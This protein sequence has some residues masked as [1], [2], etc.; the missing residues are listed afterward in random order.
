MICV[1]SGSSVS[2]V[3]GTTG[4]KV[5]SGSLP[6]EASQISVAAFDALTPDDYRDSRD[7]RKTERLLGKNRAIGKEDFWAGEIHGRIAGL[8]LCQRRANQEKVDGLRLGSD[9][10][11]GQGCSMQALRRCP[12]M[13]RV[14]SRASLRR[15]SESHRCAGGELVSRKRSRG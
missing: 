4:R 1:I 14:T 10:M 15:R 6:Q 7:S 2:K 5:D 3:E 11:E 12:A 8:H 9:R 13:V